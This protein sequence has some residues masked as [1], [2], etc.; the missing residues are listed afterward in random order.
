ME[1]ARELVLKH[2]L[3]HHQLV[4]TV[5]SPFLTTLKRALRMFAELGGL[6]E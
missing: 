4:N 6:L 5:K 2:L 1:N 3:E